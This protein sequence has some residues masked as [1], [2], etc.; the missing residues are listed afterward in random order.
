[1]SRGTLTDAIRQ[2]L[3]ANDAVKD[4]RK[5]LQLAREAVAAAVA[6]SLRDVGY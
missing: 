6:Q 5:Y 2:Y 1:M 4:P 3:D